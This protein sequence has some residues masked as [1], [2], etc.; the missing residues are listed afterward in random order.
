VKDIWIFQNIKDNVNALTPFF[1]QTYVECYQ[2]YKIMWQ[3]D[4]VFIQTLNKFHIA[5]KNTKNIQ[6]IIHNHPTILLFHIFFIQINLCKNTRAY[7]QLGYHFLDTKLKDF[8]SAIFQIYSLHGI[9]ISEK[10]W[11]IQ[12]MIICMVVVIFHT[13]M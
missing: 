3:F 4:M 12:I 13:H 7:S 2:L 8:V 1:W 9:I 5:T 10:Y 6:F 11:M